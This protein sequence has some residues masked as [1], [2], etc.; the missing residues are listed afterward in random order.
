MIEPASTTRPLNDERCRTVNVLVVDDVAQNLIA[1]EAVL[2]GDGVHVLTARSGAT[3][4]SCCSMHEVALALVDVQM[5]GMDGFEL[6]ELMRGAE[7]TA[8]MPIIFLTAAPHDRGRAFRGYDAGAVDFL[9]QADRPAGHSQQGG[10][11]SCEL[12]RQRQLLAQRAAKLEQALSLNETMLAVLTHDLRT[13]LSVLSLS[14]DMLERMDAPPQVRQIGQRVQRS[15]GRM[16][17]MI[18]QLLDFTRIRSGV[19]RLQPRAG[20]LATT[21]NQ[22]VEEAR[23]AH[24]GCTIRVACTGDTTG[25]FDADRMAQAV[26]NVIGNAAL[27]ADGDDVRVSVVGTSGTALVV[28][29]TNRGHIDAALLPRI[30]EPFKGMASA[31]SGLGLG[32]Y[33]VDQ[34][35]RAHGGAAAALNDGDRVVLRLAIPRRS[36][37]VA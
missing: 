11:S 6:A 3:R 14:G 17:R 18:E 20:D 12:H 30:F 15:A 37:L 25:V 13:P 2:R 9:L 33:I 19:L 5:P 36:P 4:S 35:V 31:S 34:F 21:V 29:V 22:I 26:C 7:R 23:Q 27:H 32:L 1:L 24:P 10:R 28:E 16:A 8:A